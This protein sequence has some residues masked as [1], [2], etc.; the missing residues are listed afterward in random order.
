[1]NQFSNIGIARAQ[2]GRYKLHKHKTQVELNSVN[3]FTDVTLARKERMLQR[4][5]EYKTPVELVLLHVIYL[6]ITHICI[7]VASN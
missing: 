5:Q 7:E 4:L 1:M 2:P 3:Q 6:F